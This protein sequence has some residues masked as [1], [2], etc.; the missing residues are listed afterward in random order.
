LTPYFEA[1]EACFQLF[2]ATRSSPI[3]NR[4]ASSQHGMAQDELDRETPI[5]E[6]VVPLRVLADRAEPRTI[7]AT[8]RVLNGWRVSIFV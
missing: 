6:G 3:P 8:I 5:F 2:F 4:R 7:D 1:F